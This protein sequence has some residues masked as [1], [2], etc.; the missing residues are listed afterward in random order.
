MN[1]QPIDWKVYFASL[2]DQKLAE[3]N[4]VIQQE[5][6]KRNSNSTPNCAELLL[7][8]S[9]KKIEAIKCYRERTHTGLAEAK[10]MIEKYMVRL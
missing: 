8:N 2:S 3:F 5:V 6:F 7:A 4:N 1:D 10:A 9:G